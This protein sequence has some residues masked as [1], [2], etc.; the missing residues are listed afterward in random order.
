V[1]DTN[2]P[3]AG[4]IAAEWWRA[5]QP[6]R[7]DGS[8]NHQAD[9][10]TLARLRRGILAQVA[11]EPAT[12]D[13]FRRLAYRQPDQLVLV[14]L[15][16]GVLAHVREDDRSGSAARQMGSPAGRPVLHP[17]R[18]NR[19]LATDAEPEARLAEFRRALAVLRHVTNVRDVAW[20]C[21]QWSDRRAQRWA[22]E[23]AGAFDAP[24]ATLNNTTNGV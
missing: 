7:R 16:A 12:I 21:L 14:A 15:C 1:L 6:L 19:L 10:G 17:T 22:L 8:R 23:Y 18:F 20:A 9:P 3:D 13:L 11:L 2:P 5:L 4:A 24:T